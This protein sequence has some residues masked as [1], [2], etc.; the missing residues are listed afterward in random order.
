MPPRRRARRPLGPLGRGRLAWRGACRGALPQGRRGGRVPQGRRASAGRLAAPRR[1]RHP[2]GRRSPGHVALAPLRPPRGRHRPRLRPG[3]DPWRTSPCWARRPSPW[4]RRGRAG[5]SRRPARALQG[6]AGPLRRAGIARSS[7]VLRAG[8]AAPRGA[9]GPRRGR[10]HGLPSGSLP[11]RGLGL[12]RPRLRRLSL[13][14]HFRRLQLRRVRLGLRC[15]RGRAQ[16]LRLRPHLGHPLTLL[17]GGHRLR[18]PGLV[19]PPRHG[20]VVA[21][22]KE[23]LRRLRHAV[24]RRVAHL[25]AQALVRHRAPAAAGRRE[26]AVDGGG[27]IAGHLPLAARGPHVDA[28]RAVHVLVVFAQGPRDGPV[29]GRRGDLPAAAAAAP[30]ERAPRGRALRRGGLLPEAR[31]ARRAAE[32]RR[33]RG[34]LREGFRREA[35]VPR[36]PVRSARA[37]VRVFLLS[38]LL[39]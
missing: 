8:R 23:V 31:S 11:L 29:L 19:S 32:A 15:L 16:H 14:L 20:R 37:R 21:V 10:R 17:V 1:R 4:L 6:A 28:L 25:E 13:R 27:L 34:R 18:A 22:R 3:G 9:D 7:Q 12:R 5:G 26:P 39:P 2:W 36:L 30:D 33:L 35:L 24:L 38:F